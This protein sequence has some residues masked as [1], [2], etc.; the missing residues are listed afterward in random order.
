M[1]TKKSFF[2]MFN[3]LTDEERQEF[4]LEMSM[5]PDFIYNYERLKQQQIIFLPLFRCSFNL[6]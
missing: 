6:S 2:K 5:R 3:S 1:I 4:Y